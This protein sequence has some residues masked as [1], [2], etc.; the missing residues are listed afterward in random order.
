MYRRRELEFGGKHGYHVFQLVRAIA[1]PQLND[2]LEKRG[3]FAS[4]PPRLSMW[5]GIWPPRCSR[6]LSDS[7]LH[8]S[9]LQRS[10]DVFGISKTCRGEAACSIPA[11]RGSSSRALRPFAQKLRIPLRTAGSSRAHAP[12]HLERQGLPFAQKLSKKHPEGR[13]F[14]IFPS[15]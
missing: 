6:E 4:G 10:E 12:R 3:R 15:E 9:R 2:Y 13:V 8:A 11:E 7:E 1:G 14:S 5:E